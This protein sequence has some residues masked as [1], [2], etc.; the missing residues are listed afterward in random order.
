MSLMPSNDDLKRQLDAA[1]QGDAA[2]VAYR[3]G[4]QAVD[5]TQLHLNQAIIAWGRFAVVKASARCS[6]IPEGFIPCG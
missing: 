2:S 4:D 5:L 6:P 1:L 3:P